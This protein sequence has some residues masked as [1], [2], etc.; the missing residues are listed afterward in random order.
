MNSSGQTLLSEILELMLGHFEGDVE[1]LKTL[2]YV[3]QDWAIYTRYHRLANIYISYHQHNNDGAS[4][5]G[6]LQALLKLLEN[7]PHIRP[8]SGLSSWT[9]ISNFLR[10]GHWTPR[11]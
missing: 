4:N 2:S 8:T 1:S 6:R 3:C 9:R 10:L 5:D 7:M 11:V